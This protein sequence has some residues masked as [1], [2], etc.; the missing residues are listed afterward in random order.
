[1]STH[2][3]YMQRCIDIAKK[4]FG[5]VAPNP[6]VGCVVA[7]EGKIISEGYHQVYGGPH[8][9]VN[10][11]S[12]LKNSDLENATVYVSLEPCFHHGK[13]PPCAEL[14][15][16]KGVKKVVVASK[17]PNPLVA[18]KGMTLLEQHGI[19]VV[20]GVLEKEAIALNRRFF[21]FHQKKRPYTI[22][23]WAQSKNGFIS[24]NNKAA[25]QR[26]HWITQKDT[27]ILNHR[28]RT[29]ENGILVG[30]NTFNE[31]KPLLTNR[32]WPGISPLRMVICNK[33][34]GL[35]QDHLKAWSESPAVVFCKQMDS[36]KINNIDFVPLG[37]EAIKT[38]WDH[39]FNNNIQSL[40]VEGGK[41]LLDQ[42]IKAK[43][44]DEAR[45]LV[46]DSYISDGEKAPEIKG[47]IENNTA[48][49]NGDSYLLIK[50]N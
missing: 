23:K 26:I 41:N 36:P 14:L 42:F 1:M 25:D 24:S 37:D 30:A 2:K 13:T 18:G 33:T 15:I 6:M 8:A 20:F 12:H 40:I 47:N 21:T 5:N 7:V 49:Q 9:E 39:C 27:Q 16:A 22:L 46:G 29:E 31:D 19:E 34:S 10:A 50:P 44:W 32:L 11:L 38:I 4:G 3:H 35:N 28:W 48:L 45:M 43:A 17:D